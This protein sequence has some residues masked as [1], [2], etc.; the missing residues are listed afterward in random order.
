[1]SPLTVPYDKLFQAP[2]SMGQILIRLSDLQIV[3]ANPEAE[4][5]YGATAEA[6]LGTSIL[7][8]TKH[9]DRT[10]EAIAAAV[11]NPHLPEQ[12]RM[13][14]RADGSSF[15]VNV[16]F[17]VFED[18]GETYLCK[19]LQDA[20]P[21]QVQE[22]L[23]QESRERF[24]AVADYTYDWESW[25]DPAGRLLWVNPAVERLTGLTP[26]ECMSLNDYPLSLIDPADREMFTRLLNGARHG[27]SGND[28]EFRVR[29]KDGR[30]NWFAVSWQ[31]IMGTLGEP[32]GF[33][34]SMR[35]ISDRKHMEEQLRLYASHLEEMVHDR[36]QQ[37]V[38]LE[39]RKLQFQKLAALGQMAASV[40][41]EINN[42]L[43]GIKNAIRLVSDEEPLS[44][45]GAKL[46][47]LVDKEIAR[48]GNLLSQMNQ[49]C[50]PT[51]SGP[52][53]FDL[54]ELLE[55][56]VAL[57]QSQWAS[58]QIRVRQVQ[59]PQ[60]LELVQHEAESRQIAHNLLLN[61]FESSELGGTVE[62]ELTTSSPDTLVIAFRDSGVGIP[63]HLLPRIFEPFVTTKH[64]YGRA[65][66]GLGL[67]ISQNLASALG[68][69][70]KAEST[71]GQGATFFWSLPT[72]AATDPD[73]PHMS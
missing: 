58:K 20:S 21:S 37:I 70:I 43:A 10:R 45:S 27:S 55:E 66:T 30:E 63:A 64:Q 26:A 46:L 59:W 11:E 51:I 23:L 19:F 3:A 73:P 47:K 42:P 24:R 48:I 22:Q 60:R 56:V 28:V 25:L 71:P 13:H 7:R 54:V 31:A 62:I 38:E 16:A 50:R 68:G 1:M 57:V 34:M 2:A 41:H 49:L 69:T 15:L 35:D 52:T 32:L 29:R 39:Q 14:V 17:A 12:R 33:R 5:L 36:A 72:R 9:P 61:A 8:W 53:K 18:Q 67:A 6:L 65:G 44:D 40:A 4:R